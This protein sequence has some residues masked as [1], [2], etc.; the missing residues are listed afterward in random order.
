M[1]RNKKDYLRKPPWIR[2]KMPG[3][4]WRDMNH[5]LQKRNLHTVCEEANCPNRGECWEL[6]TA[7]IMILGDVCT[8]GCRFCNVKTGN[9]KG[10]IDKNEINN[11]VDMTSIM[12]LKYV[13]ITSVDRDDLPDFGASHFSDVVKAVCSNHPDIKVE[14]LIPDFGGVEKHMH[15]LAKSS[16]FVIAHNIE[17][18]EGL[19]PQVRDK[20]AGYKKS[21]EVLNFYKTNYPHIA[22]KSSIMVGIGETWDE[23]VRTL[24]DLR[25]NKVNIVTLGQ[26]LRP[27]RKS[28]PV[29]KYYT[30]EE[31]EKLKDIAIGMGFDFVASAPMVRSS[32]RA[33][34]YMVFLKKSE[35]EK[36]N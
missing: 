35:S 32:Y 19:T 34:D 15:T 33:S 11:A 14:V 10:V 5:E 25:E 6:K 21:M 9:P 2:S 26:Y 27:S 30:P 13:V 29:E 17:T 24:S 18:V 4:N 1:D 16:P 7:T 3:K 31:F 23:I 22:T 12:G 36:K 28:L 20:R 8:R